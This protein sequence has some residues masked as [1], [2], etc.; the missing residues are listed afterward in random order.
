MPPEFSLH[1]SELRD[2]QRVDG[3]EERSTVNQALRCEIDVRAWTVTDVAAVT[4]VLVFQGVP[5]IV[6]SSE[7]KALLAVAPVKSDVVTT[8]AS[9]EDCLPMLF[10]T[11]TAV[12][13]CQAVD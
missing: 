2:T 13:D 5:R 8:T 7:L 1:C 4:G 9:P 11:L 3:V 6:A 12:D 10:L